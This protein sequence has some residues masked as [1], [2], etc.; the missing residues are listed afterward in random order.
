MTVLY[1]DPD[2]TSLVHVIFGGGARVNT[3]YEHSDFGKII[4]TGDRLVTEGANSFRAILAVK[5]VDPRAYLGRISS[6]NFI[7]VP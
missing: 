5:G 4:N 7:S 1:M 6:F 3:P 2:D